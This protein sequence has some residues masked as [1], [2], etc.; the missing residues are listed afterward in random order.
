MTHS[1]TSAQR[2]YR[3]AARRCDY[4]DNLPTFRQIAKALKMTYDEIEDAVACYEG[5]GILYINYDDQAPRGLWTMWASEDT[6]GHW[7]DVMKSLGAMHYRRH[8]ESY[9]SRWNLPP[10]LCGNRAGGRVTRSEKRVTCC[11]CRRNLYGDGHI[12]FSMSFRAQGY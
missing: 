8:Y 10:A 5:D 3:A 12:T 6:G 2:V 7:S 11:N 1:L 4:F 9:E